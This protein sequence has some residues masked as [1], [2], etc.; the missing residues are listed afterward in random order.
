ML[1]IDTCVILAGGFGSRITEETT[2]KPKPM[3]L[4]GNLPIIHHI[5]NFYSSYGVNR[6]IIC[7]GYKSD[8]IKKYFYDY[9][10]LHGNLE[11]DFEKKVI[12]KIKNPITLKNWNIKII[13]TGLES[14]TG[15]RLKPI[16]KHINCENFFLTYG[17]GLS[18]I[19]LNKLEK[20]HLKNKPLVTVTAVKK[21]ERFGGLEINSK[22]IVTKFMEK[23]LVYDQFI[24]GGFFVVNKK[25]EK[26][27]K[28]KKTSWEFDV[29]ANLSNAKKVNAF[30]H[31][32]FWQCMDNLR[33]KQLL[34]DLYFQKKAPWII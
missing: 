29:L 15:G 27:I 23:K 18:D 33:E 10:N 19:N 22:N 3:V 16:F 20:E 24:N 6:F 34:E 13:D 1:K 7:A 30:K 9:L 12:N 2:D 8:V 32:G 25:V 17:D 14:N 5:M 26:Y 4:I 28:S 21:K 31:N 11:F